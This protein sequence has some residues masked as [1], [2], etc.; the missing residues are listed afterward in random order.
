MSEGRPYETDNSHYILDCQFGSIADPARLH[1]EISAIT[2]VMETGFF[3]QMA[4]VVI[5]GSADGSAR[6]IQRP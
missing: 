2:G 4:Q 5:A 3:I 6:V 1:E